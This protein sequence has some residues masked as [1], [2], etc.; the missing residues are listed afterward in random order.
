VTASAQNG[1]HGG[2]DV[3]PLGIGDDDEAGRP[4]RLQH[5]LQGRHSGRPAP[6]EEGH[7]GLDHGHDAG[8]R[9]DAPH[10]ERADSPR[11]VGQPPLLEQRRGRIDAGA[12][13]P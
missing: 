6:L 12:Q 8:E 7:L 3:R 10:P 4:G 5:G 13:R 11:I 9:L 2:V 1:L